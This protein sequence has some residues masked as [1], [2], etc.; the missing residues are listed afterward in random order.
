MQVQIGK[1]KHR[2]GCLTLGRSSGSLGVVFGE[3][4]DRYGGRGSPAKLS[5]MGRERER[6]GLCEMGQGS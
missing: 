3:L 5:G 4:E 2:S 1:T 6:A